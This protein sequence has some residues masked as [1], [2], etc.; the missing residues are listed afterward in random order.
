[1]NLAALPD[2]SA[3]DPVT[4]HFSDEVSILLQLARHPLEV[5]GRSTGGN[6]ILMMVFCSKDCIGAKDRVLI[7]LKTTHFEFVGVVGVEENV[8]NDLLFTFHE[9]HGPLV[10]LVQPPRRQRGHR[11]VRLCISGHDTAE[12]NY[13]LQIKPATRRSYH[14]KWT[15]RARHFPGVGAPPPGRWRAQ[16][17]G[18][19]PSAGIPCASSKITC[20]DVAFDLKKKRSAAVLTPMKPVSTSP[21]TKLGCLARSF[22]NWTLVLGPTTLY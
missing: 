4:I 3:T 20:L 18:L 12:L 10:P 6:L 11:R 13:F 8:H 15:W 21:A 22:R 16:K 7:P 2:D 1:M 19:T 17:V 14:W 5:S 9:L